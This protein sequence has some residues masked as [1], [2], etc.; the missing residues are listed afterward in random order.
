MPRSPIAAR[1][2]L[3]LAVVVL[4]LAIVSTWA[5]ATLIETDRYVE[6]VA[7][8]ATD[9]IVQATIE[10][11]LVREALD[12]LDS[13][14]ASAVQRRIERITGL[15]ERAANRVVRDPEFADAWA[16]ANRSA[17]KEL[18]AVL[19]GEQSALVSDDG[20]VSIQL[21]TLLTT[22]FSILDNEGV[23]DETQ[24]PE[25]EASFTIASAGDLERAKS[26]YRLVDTLG[27][28]LPLLWLVLFVAAVILA[29]DRRRA[30]RWLGLG[31]VVAVLL[32][33]IGLRVGRDQLLAAEFVSDPAV[34][35]AIW[36]IL[37]VGLKTSL[38]AI[39]GAAILIVAATLIRGGPVS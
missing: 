34:A 28:W 30:L 11:A 39:G 26:A 29:K 18:L 6:T 7:P 8:L 24:L 5:K 21:D 27:F 25:L 20:R 31:A 4:P 33:A 14:E 36:D 13:V 9:P 35:N 38:W 22:V 2:A 37:I 17:H 10:D 16:G 19:S 32:V 1:L 12:A 3:A 15:L 23:V